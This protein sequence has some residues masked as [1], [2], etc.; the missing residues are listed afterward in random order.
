MEQSGMPEAEE[1]PAP[2]PEMTPLEAG[3]GELSEDPAPAHQ[4][5]TSEDP[6]RGLGGEQG[7]Y[8]VV[9]ESCVRSRDGHLQP[10]EPGGDMDDLWERGGARGDIAEPVVSTE[11][12]WI[13]DDTEHRDESCVPGDERSFWL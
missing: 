11:D 8:D 2:A 10:P 9:P 7:L 4:P 5:D 13:H 3:A 6:F 1:A 12:G